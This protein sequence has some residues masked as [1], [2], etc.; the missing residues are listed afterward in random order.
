[1]SSYRLR[2]FLLTLHG[3]TFRDVKLLSF[4]ASEGMADDEEPISFK[5]KAIFRPDCACITLATFSVLL[6]S[7]FKWWRTQHLRWLSRT[8]Y[9]NLP[10]VA[11]RKLI[12]ANRWNQRTIRKTRYVHH[13]SI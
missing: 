1:V 13:L 10:E 11:V 4:G 7:R 12:Q 5:K 3:G 8:L 6:T 2:C 9:R